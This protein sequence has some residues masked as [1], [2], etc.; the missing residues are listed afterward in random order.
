[1]RLTNRDSG[2][3]RNLTTQSKATTAHGAASGVYQITAKA[4]GFALLERTATVEAGTT[5]TVNLA[6]QIGASERAGDGE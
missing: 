1:V 4:T 2:L 6:L 5:T 3:T